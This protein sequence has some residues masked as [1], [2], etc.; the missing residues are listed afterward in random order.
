VIP[1]FDSFDYFAALFPLLVLLVPAL[2]LLRANTA[3]LSLLIV[4]GTY[5]I[6]LIAPRLALFH[7][8]MW[9]VVAGLQIAVSLTGEG[10]HGTLVLWAAL[11]VTLAP[12]VAW[13]AWPIEFVVDFNLWT[14]RVVS[15]PSTWLEAVDFNAEAIAPVGLSF[16]AFRAADLLIKSNLGLVERLHPGRVLA[17]G[18]FP[19]LL[20]VGP[21]AS[22]D[23][24]AKTLDHRI[25][26][27]TERVVSGVTQILTGMFKVFVIAFLLDWSTDLF[28][29][30]ES[31]PPWRIWIALIAFGW[32]FYANFAGYSDMAI[33]AGR[34]LGGDLRPNFERPYQQTD[35][36]AFWNGWHMSLTR[37][38]RVNVFTP[39]AAGR[40]QRQHLAT[41]VTMMLIALW[42]GISWAT[43]VFGLYHSASLI[44][45]RVLERRRPPNEAR[46]VRIGKAVL[47]FFWFVLSL[48]LL[49]LDL[50]S[51]I[52]FYR[53]MVGL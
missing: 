34:L 3:R 44:G 2:A 27:Q 28:Q 14:N 46:L 22:Y 11:F 23:E 36:N 12:V 40:P 26:L 30:F 39:I 51:A 25:P 21:I 41:F 15:A 47:I 29:V 42:H 19:P 13:K 50:D 43:V 48:P 10:R 20:V 17:Y 45:H 18:L 49:Q 24:T 52:D 35:P 31:N 16:A 5:L 7:L 38:M 9:V 53:A 33:G 8:V 32:Y 37:F 6:F 1:A 4:A